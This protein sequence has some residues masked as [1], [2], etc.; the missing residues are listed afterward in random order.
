[1][2]REFFQEF[3]VAEERIGWLR[4]FEYLQEGK[5]FFGGH[6]GPFRIAGRT[7]LRIKTDGSQKEFGLEE[8]QLHSMPV[9]P[10]VS[11]PILIGGEGGRRYVGS[12]K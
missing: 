12:T 11:P 3:L 9:A 4:G 7:T 5:L 10:L 2:L 1:M 8:K 6:G